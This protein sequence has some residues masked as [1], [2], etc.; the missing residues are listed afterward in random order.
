MKSRLFTVYEDIEAQMVGDF[1]GPLANLG[2]T[3]ELFAIMVSVII[4]ILCVRGRGLAENVREGRRSIRITGNN[5]AIG[6]RLD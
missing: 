1:F 3:G 6:G 2:K 4:E 5:R